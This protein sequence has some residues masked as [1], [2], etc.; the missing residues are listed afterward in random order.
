MIFTHT[1]RIILNR[2]TN[3]LPPATLQSIS[4]S[5]ALALSLSFWVGRLPRIFS[6]I[7]ANVMCVRF[8]SRKTSTCWVFSNVCWIYQYYI[9]SRMLKWIEWSFC[10]CPRFLFFSQFI[11]FALCFF[12]VPLIN[13][14][15][16]VPKENA[17]TSL[18]KS[19]KWQK[20]NTFYEFLL[21]TGV[22]CLS[23]NRHSVHFA[24]ISRY[25]DVPCRSNV[26]HTKKN[27]Q[28]KTHSTT[29]T[30]FSPRVEKQRAQ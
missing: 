6:F 11:F 8:H 15:M 25:H 7:F 26:E 4:L 14:A 2:R 24:A 12:T 1:L 27:V 21:E 3:F 17:P 28:K 16:R 5:R 10:M 20:L 13:G 30:Y 22:R 9:N 23:S 19:M 29:E 18:E